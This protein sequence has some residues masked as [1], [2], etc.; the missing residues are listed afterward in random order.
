MKR[1]ALKTISVFYVLFALVMCTPAF[2][3]PIPPTPTSPIGGG[4]LMLLGAG[5][6]Y[7]I[8]RFFKEKRK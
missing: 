1:K 3:Q 2:A 8:I 5:A 4:L 6:V 7:G